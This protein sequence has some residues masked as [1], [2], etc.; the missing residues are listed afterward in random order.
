MSAHRPSVPTGYDRTKRVLTSRPDCVVTVGF[1]TTQTNLPRFLVQLHYISGKDPTEWSSIARVDHNETSEMGHD[2]YEEGLH[3][4][5]G[6]RTSPEV[7]RE[8]PQPPLPS[9]RGQVLRACA[10]YLSDNADWFVDAYEERQ[11]PD[12]PPHWSLDGGSPPTLL[13]T[14][15]GDRDMSEQEP[16]ADAITM[17]ELSEVIAEETDETAEEIEEGAAEIDIGPP[18]EGEYVDK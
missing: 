11:A 9:S 10:N 13:Q 1:D 6:R 3:V 2:V 17:E 12:N 8:P 14:D 16:V 5:I 4:D 18:W 7:T 15:P